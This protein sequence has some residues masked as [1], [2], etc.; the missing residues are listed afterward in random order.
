M[1][2]RPLIRPTIGHKHLDRLQIIR[3]DRRIR[4]HANI[5]GD[6][7]IA[8]RT[9]LKA[10]QRLRWRRLRWPPARGNARATRPSPA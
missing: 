7:G 1:A 8:P 4:E 5:A 10:N 3:Q 9:V 2:A 6:I